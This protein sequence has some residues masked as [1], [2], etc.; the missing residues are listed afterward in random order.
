MSKKS[1]AVRGFFVGG[2][3]TQ[4]PTHRTR[5]MIS[6]MIPVPRDAM[7]QLSLSILFLRYTLPPMTCSCRMRAAYCSSAQASHPSMNDWELPLH[8]PG[9]VMPLS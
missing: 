7:N 5:P 6:I 3:F 8:S 1:P 2:Y 9:S 4:P